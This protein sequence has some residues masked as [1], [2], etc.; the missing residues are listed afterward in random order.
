MNPRRRRRSRRRDRARREDPRGLDGRS[1][2]DPAAR[3]AL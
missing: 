1:R 2:G 3:R